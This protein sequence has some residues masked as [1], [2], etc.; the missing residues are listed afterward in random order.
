MILV[1]SVLVSVEDP[2]AF[3]MILVSAA[4][5]LAWN[6][7]PINNVAIRDIAIF[8]FVKLLLFSIGISVSESEVF[9]FL[10]N[11]SAWLPLHNI[12][13]SSRSIIRAVRR[14]GRR[15]V[16]ARFERGEQQAKPIILAVDRLERPR[17]MLSRAHSSTTSNPSF[18]R[19]GCALARDTCTCEPLTTLASSPW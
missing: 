1:P 2:F 10:I 19:Y 17:A 16:R 11:P 9:V 12:A 4:T 7:K 8:C 5:A 13:L 18:L 15:S 3:L 6:D 14:L